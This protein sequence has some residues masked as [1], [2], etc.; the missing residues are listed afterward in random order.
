L[1]LIS[2]CD[3][4]DNFQLIRQ[5]ISKIGLACVMM[6]LIDMVMPAEDK[7]EEIFDLTLAS[8]KELELTRN[9]DKIM[10]IFKIKI[11]ASSG[12]KPHFDSCVSCGSKI[13]DQSKFSLILGGL[14]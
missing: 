7:N 1:H 5:S 4:K 9:P 14:L 10:T 13:F 6:E 11:L 2:S 12:F 3:M 8:L